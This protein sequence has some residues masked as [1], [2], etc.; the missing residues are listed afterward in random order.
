MNYPHL[1]IGRFHEHIG[2]IDRGERYEDPLDEVLQARGAGRVTG[3]GS[4][5][6]EQGGIDFAEVEIELADLNDALDLVIR[7]LE[8]AGA[9]LG[10]EILS[11]GDVIRTFGTQQCVAVYLDGVSLPRDVYENLDFGQVVADL[12]AAAGPRSYHGGW[13]GPEET[14]LYLFGPDAEDLFSRIDPVLRALPIG[15]NARVVVNVERGGTA[16]REVRL[17]RH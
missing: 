8:Q 10:S 15:Q 17:P 6:N 11:D 1:V 12:E 13:Q 3:G 16:A 2:P 14:A 5:L 4:Q 9:P 7:A